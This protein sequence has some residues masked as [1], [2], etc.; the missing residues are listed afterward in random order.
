MVSPGT[1]ETGIR[2]VHKSMHAFL[3][4]A[5]DATKDAAS[6]LDSMPDDF[7]GA[8]FANGSKRL[9]GTLKAIKCMHLFALGYGERFVIVISADFTS[10]H[11]GSFL[12]LFSIVLTTFEG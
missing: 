4:S 2:P 8:M 3:G 11:R 6:G 1:D 9:N 10:C 7:A 12:F 5:I